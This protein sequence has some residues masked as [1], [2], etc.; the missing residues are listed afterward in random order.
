MVPRHPR[1]GSNPRR[2]RPGNVR[3]VDTQDRTEPGVR[4][5]EM[6][7]PGPEPWLV[8]DTGDDIVVSRRSED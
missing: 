2:V 7:G 4:Q 5:P 6:S 1:N 8:P 3:R